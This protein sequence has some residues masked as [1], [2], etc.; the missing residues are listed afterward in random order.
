[1]AT[2]ARPD[3]SVWRNDDAYEHPL[4]VRGWNL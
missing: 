1:M 2:T 4:R 3:L